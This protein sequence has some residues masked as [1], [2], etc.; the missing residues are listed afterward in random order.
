M[1][2]LEA[3]MAKAA[4]ECSHAAAI[5]A[6]KG[7]PVLCLGCAV[8][9]AEEYADQKRVLHVDMG[10]GPD[11]SVTSLVKRCGE[12]RGDGTRCRREAGHDGYH[13]SHEDDHPLEWALR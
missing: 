9:A 7:D 6:D 8:R 5:G 13:S 2:G 11:R 10:S 1:L 3:F 12:E 4:K